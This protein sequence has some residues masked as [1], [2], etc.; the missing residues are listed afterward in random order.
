VEV[1][2]TIQKSLFADVPAKVATRCVRETPAYR[3]AFQADNCSLQELLA[4]LIGGRGAEEKALFLIQ[5]FGTLHDMERSLDGELS[6]L[7]GRAAALRLKAGFALG[8]KAVVSEDDRPSVSSPLDAKNILWPL[9]GQK[10][11]ENLAVLVLD[12]RNRLIEAKIIYQG[13][14]NCSMVRVAEVLRP[15]IV[16]NAPAIV[17]GHNHP[18]SDPS[19]S[20]EDVTL[21]RALISSCK[22]FDLDILDH[23]VVTPVAAFTSMKEK[24]LAF[25]GR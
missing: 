12:T 22:T 9:I 7:I 18:S 13:S 11:Q 15:A 17:V 10:D 3:V 4:A 5:H 6:K 24:G 8:H 25:G 2:L 19:P 23:I 14:V 21:T 20:P 16:R 1:L